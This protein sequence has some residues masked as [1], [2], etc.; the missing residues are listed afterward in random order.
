VI[1][2]Y[3]RMICRY[4]STLRIGPGSQSRKRRF[5]RLRP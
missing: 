1:N 3:N 2:F 5:A 4:F